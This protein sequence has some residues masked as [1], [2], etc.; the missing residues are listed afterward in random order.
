MGNLSDL[1]NLED[2]EWI[3]H[4][5]SSEII[6]KKVLVTD[7]LYIFFTLT[8]KK[9]FI[10]IDEF[11]SKK[12]LYR[13]KYT[14]CSIYSKQLINTSLSFS[15]HRFQNRREK[16]S[17]LDG[18][19]ESRKNKI[20]LICGAGR[21]KQVAETFELVYTADETKYW[22]MSYVVHNK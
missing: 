21:G 22:Q 2:I 5:T 16:L 8:E 12:E 20:S 6:K 11:F 7:I 14:S 17:L 1:S 19:N 15:L 3:K 9:S 4:I 10:W 18:S 13:H